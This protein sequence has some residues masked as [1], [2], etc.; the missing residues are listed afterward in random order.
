MKALQ[1][2]Y[3]APGELK[4]RHFFN[5]SGDSPLGHLTPTRKDEMREK[6]YNVITSTKS[7][8]LLAVVVDQSRCEVWR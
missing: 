6:L 2:E 1:D 5:R 7:I 4:W 8:R 3:Q